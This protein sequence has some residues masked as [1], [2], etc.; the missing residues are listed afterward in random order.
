MIV[1]P[2]P[3]ARQAAKLQTR[4]I[5][6][7]NTASVRHTTAMLAFVAAT[8]MQ[9]SSPLVISNAGPAG[10][11]I[12]RM[13]PSSD[14]HHPAVVVV[15]DG[16]TVDFEG[17]TL[18]GSAD[19]TEPDART[20]LG[21]EVRGRNVTI[22]NL[23]VR[24]YFVGILAR[25]CPNLKLINCDASFNWKQR[26]K[27]GLDKEDLADWMSYHKNDHDEWLLGRPAEGVPA[28]GGA[29]YLRGCDNVEIKGCRATGGQNGLMMT[30]CNG[31]LVWNCDFSFLSA[32][33]I[34]MYRSSGNRIMHNRVDWCVRGYS[35]GVYNR[36]QDSAGI[37]VYEQSSKNVFA[38]NSVTHGGD[39][40]FLWA[41][42][43]TMDSGKGGCNDNLVYG[44]DFSHAPTNGIEAT[45]SRNTFANNLVMECWH[46]VWGGYSFE[47]TIEGNEFRR[48]QEAIAI[49]HGQQNVIRQ[50]S[51]YRDGIG[52]NLWMND[53][54]DP[55]WGYPKHRDT[56][57][58]G[59]TIDDNYFL[60]IQSDAVR[61]RKT[62][63]VQ[64]VGN[65]FEWCGS[66][67]KTDGT[68]P[69]KWV[70]NA[71]VDK[72]LPEEDVAETSPSYFA[73]SWEPFGTGEDR[74]KN[75][76][77]LAPK[78]LKGG[79]DP[80]LARSALRGRRYILVDEWGP[81]DF[82][83]PLLWPRR[84]APQSAEQPGGRWQRFEV[85]GPKGTWRVLR[86]DGAK[87]SAQQGVVPGFVE[88]WTSEEGATNIDIEL[89][90]VGDSTRDYHGIETP[91][92]RPIR[93]GYRKFVLPIDWKVDFFKWSVAAD[94]ADV[95]S[96]PLESAIQTIFQRQ[97]I[98]SLRLSKLDFAGYAFDPATGNDHYATVATGRFSVPAG[99]YR[100]ELTTDDG[101]RVWLD[102]KPLIE[103]AWKYQ[104]PTSYARDV[105][106]AGS[107]QIR[108]EHFQ[109]DGYAALKLKIEPKR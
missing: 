60:R 27:S 89:E 73:N 98:K 100:I 65:R 84:E 21:L 58:H 106:L 88:V 36:G 82:K 7:R 11:R 80:F 104:G 8:W 90:F 50:N 107:H 78:P 67:L 85:L 108:V 97:P 63:E 64:A 96:A 59:Y 66:M 17:K 2:Q 47:T 4:R 3:N 79:M 23:N 68:R 32:L 53:N 29:F 69:D 44:N 9:G 93:F 70:D 18:R 62:S 57:S 54:Q 46:G 10:S 81:Y 35:H 33:G 43:S 1:P 26:L 16:L 105:H 77:A 61:L 13:L 76:E 5:S 48:N 34:G 49:E 55:N 45:F 38:Y 74:R 56:V 94:P 103:D 91:K 15:G 24:G 75:I 87:L 92:G 22:K 71:M 25:N 28:Y 52:V 31:G 41:G 95:H 37:L 109:I 99:E 39:G 102:G 40:F 19:S 14:V 83:R 30:E 42:N 72:P 86:S 20:G 101:A 51:F 12:T 6:H